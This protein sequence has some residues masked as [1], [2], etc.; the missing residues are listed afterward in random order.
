M[1]K[2]I[3]M[4]VTALHVIHCNAPVPEAVLEDVARQQVNVIMAGGHVVAG[5]KP[6]L[7]RFRIRPDSVIDDN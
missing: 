3:T 1:S 5:P 2:K 7:S 6:C 4:R